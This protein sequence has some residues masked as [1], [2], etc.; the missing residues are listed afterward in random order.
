MSKAAPWKWA[1]VVLLVGV[2]AA[3]H[4]WPAP[5]VKVELL[6]YSDTPPAWDGSYPHLLISFTDT[7]TKPQ[8]KF[9]ISMVA[10]TVRHDN[11][12]DEFEATCIPD[13]SFCGRPTC[14][15]PM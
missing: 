4:W 8:F 1:L 3:I 15:S 2:A 7:S 12:V 9:S 6:P 10:P 5:P 14:S 13:A 11:P